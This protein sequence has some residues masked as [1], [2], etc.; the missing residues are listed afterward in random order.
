MTK[1]KYMKAEFEKARKR[2][3]AAELAEEARQELLEEEVEEKA[4]IERLAR[5]AKNSRAESASF[6][7]KIQVD[8]L[9]K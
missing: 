3:E 8:M 7:S 1:V 5:S 9:T 2:K 6:H 4:G